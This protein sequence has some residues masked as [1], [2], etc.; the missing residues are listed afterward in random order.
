MVLQIGCCVQWGSE[1]R[2]F[3]IRIHSK[4]G[5]F[6]GRFLNGPDFEGLV[7]TKKSGFR[8]V[9]FQVLGCVIAILMLRD[10][11]LR[12]LDEWFPTFLGPVPPPTFSKYFEHGLINKL[13]L[14][15][16]LK[17]KFNGT[18]KH[19]KFKEHNFSSIILML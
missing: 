11:P 3:K 13:G 1:N 9:S 14:G 8:M 7:C 2:P 15:L 16:G 19:K 17:S 4:S 18:I 5:L 12:S 6:A 10:C